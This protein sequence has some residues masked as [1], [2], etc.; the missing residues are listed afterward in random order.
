[1]VEDLGADLPQRLGG[2]VEE[3]A[4]LEALGVDPVRGARE[5]HRRVAQLLDEPAR[6]GLGRL[7]GSRLDDHHDVLELAEV[8]RVLGVALHVAR[9]LGEH[10]AAGGLEAQ[11][12]DGGDDAEE[13]EEQGQRDR[14]VRAS[15]RHPDE[16][17]KQATGPRD[18]DHGADVEQPDECS[19]A[20]E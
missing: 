15:A 1:V 17:A 19:I 3:L 2:E 10:V 13:G 16:A 6:V 8:A 5:V 11:A 14:H 12:L 7:E 20:V 9:V 18:G 4:A